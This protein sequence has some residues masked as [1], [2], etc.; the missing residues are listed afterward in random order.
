MNIIVLY[1][2]FL[3]IT[4]TT[5]ESLPLAGVANIFF[6]S[7]IQMESKIVWYVTVKKSSHVR[8]SY[9]QHNFASLFFNFSVTFFRMLASFHA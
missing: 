1:K 8:I 4:Y 7:W 2:V 9:K 5:I 6:F 3:F